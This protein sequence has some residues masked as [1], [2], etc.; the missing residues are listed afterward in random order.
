MRTRFIFTVTM[1]L[2]AAP[3]LAEDADWRESAQTA[4]HLL[5][6]VGVDYPEFV[7]DGEVLDAGRVRGAA[8]VRREGGGASSRDFRSEPDRARLVA[9]AEALLSLVK[10]KGPG[11]Q[12]ASASADL[13]WALI[14]AY[15]L[16]VA[17]KQVPDLAHGA[18]ST[19]PTA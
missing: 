5:D 2:L 10:A 16:V 8:R 17:P 6:Y 15:A 9:D 19:A 13:R 12:V 7:R 3:A 4:L 11:P 18:R 14:G 1:L